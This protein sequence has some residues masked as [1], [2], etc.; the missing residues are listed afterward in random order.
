MIVYLLKTFSKDPP[1]TYNIILD[2]LFISTK[3]IIYFL[4]KGFGAYGITRTNTGIY[5]D[6]LDYN[7]S[8]KNNIIS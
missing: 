5:Q 4:A 3:F 8:N 7:K 6:L 1:G 2:N